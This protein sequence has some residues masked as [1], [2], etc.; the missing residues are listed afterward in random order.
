MI[1]HLCKLDRAIN[2]TYVRIF[3]TNLIN[4][5]QTMNYKVAEALYFLK[6]TCEGLKFGCNLTS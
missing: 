3:K 4:I 6:L 2:S 5:H 1:L